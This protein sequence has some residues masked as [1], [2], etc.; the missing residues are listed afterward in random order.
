M[1]RCYLIQLANG[2]DLFADRFPRLRKSAANCSCEL[3][4]TTATR[5]KAK[6]DGLPEVWNELERGLML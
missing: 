5:R 6:A 3:A 2:F 1:L 4:V